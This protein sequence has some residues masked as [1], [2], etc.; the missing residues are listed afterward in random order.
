[1][2]T[3]KL[4]SHGVIIKSSDNATSDESESKLFVVGQTDTKDNFNRTLF[5][6]DYMRGRAFPLEYKQ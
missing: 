2:E 1:M 5:V 4:I 6:W 3:H